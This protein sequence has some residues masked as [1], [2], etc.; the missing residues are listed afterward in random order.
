MPMRWLGWSA[1][2]ASLLLVTAVAAGAQ[3]PRV[4]DRAAEIDLAAL[5]GGRVVLSQLRGHP[6][7][8]SFWGSWCPPCRDEFPELVRAFKAHGPA[9]LRMIGVNG[10][11]QERR[12]KDVQGFVDEYA[13]T[14][15]IAL[16]V[17]GRARRDY[18]LIGLPTTVFVDS[19]GVVRRIHIGPIGR[20]QLTDGIATIQPPRER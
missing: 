16:D 6:V 3:L 13:V 11:D 10:R 19:S 17:R 15:P 1:V 8:I 2:T 5:D 20:E 9:G 18:G 4:G 7:V 14:F 12:T